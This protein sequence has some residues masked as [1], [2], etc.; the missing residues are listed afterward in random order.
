MGWCFTERAC[1]RFL[2]HSV[3]VL[4]H[5]PRQFQ[6]RS[7]HCP[8]SKANVN[9]KKKKNP[10]S[11]IFQSTKI[12]SWNIVKGCMDFALV[13]CRAV[14]HQDH[15]Y[16]IDR[17]VNHSRASRKGETAKMA[18]IHCFKPFSQS[19]FYFFFPTSHKLFFLIFFFS[20]NIINLI[21]FFFFFL[22]EGAHR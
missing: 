7:P 18:R 19:L 10:F 11:S 5:L 22:K 21:K 12:L 3:H 14:S 16:F 20:E 8:V 4:L 13:I 9:L 1:P 15:H 17:N 6:K 2:K